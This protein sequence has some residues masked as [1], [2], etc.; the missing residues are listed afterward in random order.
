M[1]ETTGISWT[2]HTFN[3]AWGCSKVSPGC[4]FCYADVLSNRFGMDIW[5]LN[6]PRR[7]FGLKHWNDPLRWNKKAVKEN[8]K[9]MAFCSSMCDIFEDH[10]TII[11]ELKK[12]WSLIKSTPNLEWQLLTKRSERILESLP[13]DWGEGYPNAW[14]GVSVENKDYEYRADHLRAAPCKIRFISY[15]PA[16]GPLDN[17]NL[18]GISWVIY[19]G[20]SGDSF[21]QDDPQWARNML[22][23]CRDNNVAF[24]YKQSSSRLSGTNP[25]LDGIEYKEFPNV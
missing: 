23:L 22:K 20:E 25:Y 10:P 24:F 7:T 3:I 14:L 19:G 8:K 2:N 1:A 5:G 9:S 4:Q 6:K 21:R 16:L 11:E 15:E 13:P 12:L 17:F 18:K